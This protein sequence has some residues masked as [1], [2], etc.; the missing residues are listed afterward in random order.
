MGV[1]SVGV[2]GWETGHGKS[3]RAGGADGAMAQGMA[4]HCQ[5]PHGHGIATSK[6]NM[7]IIVKFS[8]ALP[9]VKSPVSRTS[10][11]IY[12]VREWKTF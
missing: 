1:R 5:A 2:E 8:E 11:T 12:V 6:V 3:S 10:G 4:H 9:C 7:G